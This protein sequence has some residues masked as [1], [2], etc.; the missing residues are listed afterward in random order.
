MNK[1]RSKLSGG[2]STRPTHP[3]QPHHQGSRPPITQHIA[4]SLCH[5]CHPCSY[6][7]HVH[8]RRDGGL[9]LRMFLLGGI[10]DHGKDVCVCV[11]VWCVCVC[12]GVCVCVCGV[13][14]CC[15]CVCV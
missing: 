12:V 10:L 8:D 15:V 13:C 11:C 2:D 7:V 5:A 6:L 9:A 14:V 4:A 3:W 1:Y